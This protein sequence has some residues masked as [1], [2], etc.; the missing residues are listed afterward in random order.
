MAVTYVAGLKTS[1]M[2]A[3]RD[4]CGGGK[5]QILTAAD[6]LIVE[7]TLTGAGGTVTGNVWT[8]A[9]D[10][11][12]VAATAGGTAAKA[13]IITSGAADAVTTLTVGTTGTDVIV[14]N[15]SIAEAQDVTVTSATV[16]HAPDPS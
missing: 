6:A 4:Y 3:T 7:F 1:R 5:L 2:T 12:T 10:A 16:T 15:T 13:K 8:L 14:N 11:S 9:V